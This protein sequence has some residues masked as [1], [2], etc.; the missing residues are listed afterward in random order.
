MSK[1]DFVMSTFIKCTQDALWEALTDA[2]TA[3]AYHFLASKVERDSNR[4][5]Y[6]TPDGGT[7]LICSETKLDPKTRIESTFEP[8]WAGPDVPLEK[9]HFVY[10]I[11]PQASFCKLTIEHYDIPPGQEGAADGWGRMLAG[12]KTISKPVRASASQTSQLRER[13]AP[14]TTLPTELG[15]LVCLTLLAASMWIPYIVGVNVHRT[16]DAN[17]FQ[18]PMTDADP[19]LRGATTAWDAVLHL[20]HRHRA[21]GIC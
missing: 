11:E 21:P 14:M 8:A 15:V 17:P 2:E 6:K 10:L 13:I 9:S 18:R 3:S 7:M 12:L 16:A 20:I 5:I 1:P 19:D 4:L